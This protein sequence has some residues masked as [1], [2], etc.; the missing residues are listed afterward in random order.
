M[1]KVQP[2]SFFMPGNSNLACTYLLRIR[3]FAHHASESLDHHNDVAQFATVYVVPGILCCKN[4]AEN[5]IA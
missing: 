2:S 1:H 4:Y 5:K 3:L